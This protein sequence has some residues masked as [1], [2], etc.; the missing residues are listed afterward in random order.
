MECECVLSRDVL[1]VVT[2]RF[3]KVPDKQAE[4]LSVKYSLRMIMNP[5]PHPVHSQR[6]E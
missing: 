4:T 3:L 1:V 5:S 2:F 6:G